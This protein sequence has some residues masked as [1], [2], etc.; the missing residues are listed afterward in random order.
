[1]YPAAA[2]TYTL[3]VVD[4]SSCSAQATTNVVINALP[5]PSASSNSPVCEGQ[6][7]NLSG[8]PDGMTSYSWTG[9]NGYTSSDQNPSINNVTLA[10]AGTYTLTVID[11]SSCSAQATTNVVINALPL[12]DCPIT[13]SVCINSAPFLLTG[14]TPLC[15]YIQGM[16]FQETISILQPPV[17]VTI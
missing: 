5:T 4:G 3:T 11:G 17:L 16:A 6:T 13:F 10:A 14:A 12:V 8:L 9:P 2:G 7:L 1:M 15:V